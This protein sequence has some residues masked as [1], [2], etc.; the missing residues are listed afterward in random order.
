MQLKID[1]ETNS[2]KEMVDISI[3]RIQQFEPPEGYYVAFSG[4]KDSIILLILMITS[5]V[6]FHLYHALTGIDPPIIKKIVDQL[7]K[8]DLCTIVKPG[9]TMWKLIPEKKMPPSRIVR[10]CCEELKEAGGKGRF[11]TTGVRHAES[12]KRSKRTLVEYDSYGSQS[13]KAKKERRKFNLMNDN[14][15][16][17]RMIEHCQI[18]G[19]NILNPIIDWSD[20][21]VWEFIHKNKSLLEAL[22]IEYPYLYDHGWDRIGCLG[23]PLAKSS[24]RI[25]EFLE[26]PVYYIN[27]LKSFD[28]MI[29]VRLDNDMDTEWENGEQVMQW[30]LEIKNKKEFTEVDR[31]IKQKYL[32]QKEKAYGNNNKIM[33]HVIKNCNR[34]I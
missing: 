2:I 19:K 20:N 31:M 16:K 33:D 18:K 25:K 13:K 6:K 27:Y 5:D 24:T 26:F 32:E 12:S 29:E 21:D 1:F 34:K 9:T 15:N 17:R 28:R 3:Q 30:W 8:Q 4:G 22:G 23:C 11:V 7:V 10:Y 14:D